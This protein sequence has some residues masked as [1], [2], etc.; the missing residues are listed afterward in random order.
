M[1]DT[2]RESL[3]ALMDN[4]ADTFEAK[5]VLQEMQDDAALR[6]TWAR[7]HWASAV[8]RNEA[9]AAEPDMVQRVRQAIDS[10]SQEVSVTGEESSIAP[11]SLPKAKKQSARLPGWW[12]SMGSAAIA[13]SVTAAVFLGIQSQQS[14]DFE[15]SNGV[16]VVATSLEGQQEPAKLIRV[17]SAST[18]ADSGQQLA[19]QERLNQYLMQHAEHSAYN[20]GRGIVPYSR[21]VNFDQSEAAAEDATVDK[22]IEAPEE[23]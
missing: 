19:V 9:Q 6:D 20:S 17:E 21:L 22:S 11:A 18:V 16:E 1:S 2:L 23:K 12:Q 7:Y 4:E 8:I 14:A 10:S 3:S 5:R 13:A 15:I